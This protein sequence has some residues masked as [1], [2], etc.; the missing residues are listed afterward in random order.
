MLNG[1]ISKINGSAG[2][3]SFKQTCGQTIISENG[4]VTTR[5]YGQRQCLIYPKK[6]IFLPFYSPKK[7][8]QRQYL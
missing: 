2:N 1:I 5:E 4:M 7:Y 3:L 8:F 6:C